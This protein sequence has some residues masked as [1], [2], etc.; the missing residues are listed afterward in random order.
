[1][2]GNQY[3]N[4]LLVETCFRMAL[5]HDFEPGKSYTTTWTRMRILIISYD[6]NELFVN[7]KE[8]WIARMDHGN[9]LRLVVL[10][11]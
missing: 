7:Q 10:K 2:T 1:M 6:W 11:W 4:P 9:N 3:L 8:D 5:G